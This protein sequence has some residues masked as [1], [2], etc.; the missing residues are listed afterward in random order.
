MKEVFWIEGEARAALAIVLRPRGDDWL[1]DELLRMRQAGIQTLVSMLEDW[2]SDSLGLSDER[3]LAEGAGLTFLSYPIP[4]RATPAEIPSFRKLIAELANR[5]RA[6]E[7]VGIHCRASIGRA[8][9]AAACALIRLG[10]NPE[11]AL[12]AVEAARGCPVPDTEE[13]EH[14]ILDYKAHA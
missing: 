13:Q 10:S 4:D 2:E 8:S 12:A 5:L 1:A 9:M 11:A 14:W 6:G 7:R 3:Q